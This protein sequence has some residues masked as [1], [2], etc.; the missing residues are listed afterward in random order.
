MNSNI[1]KNQL[2][3]NQCWRRIIFGRIA[4]DRSHWIIPVRNINMADN[5]NKYEVIHDKDNRE[6]YIK[7][8]NGMY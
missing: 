1:I 4:A 2:V 5:S 8:G 7:V 6:F 3:L